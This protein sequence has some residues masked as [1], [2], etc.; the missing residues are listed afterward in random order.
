M[1]AGRV[2]TRGCG[3]F[4]VLWVLLVGAYAY[5][6]YGRIHE[7]MPSG[8]IGVLGGTFALLFISSFVGL[9]TGRRDRVAL[10]RAMSAEPLRDGHLEAVSGP[11]R[12]TGQPLEA[13]FSGQPCVAY[14]YDVKRQG[15]GQ[16]DF[17]GVAMAPCAV[18]SLRGQARV[19]G[20]VT[21]DQFPSTPDDRI[22]RARAVRYLSSAPSEPL[23]VLT[24][25]SVFKELITDD[26]GAI[27][28]DFKIGA[29]TIELSGRRIQERVL[30]AGA[31]VTL[32]GY[33]S[34][35][36]QGFAPTG[37]AMNRIFPGDLVQTSHGMSGSSIKTFGMATFF[38]L[39]LHAM[40][41][42][43]YIMAGRPGGPAAAGSVWDERDCDRQKT[44]L[45]R[46]ADPNERGSDAITPLMNAA[47]MDEAACV[48][49]LIAAGARLEDRD[50]FSDTALAHA[51]VANRDENITVLLEAGAKDFR[52][53]AANGRP[54]ADTDAPVA[55]V[56][57]YIDALYREDFETMARLMA[58]S[59]VRRMEDMRSDLA[60]WQSLRPKTFTA[61]EGWMND[62]AATLTIHG[63]TSTGE[64]HIAYHVARQADGWQ[65][66]KEWFL[67]R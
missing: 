61:G 56:H 50:R 21:L 28:K 32:L 16:S 52:V 39:V 31:M 14:D 65:I 55:A 27:R 11:I 25:L 1:A 47:R 18:E 36:R 20:W 34:E 22:D 6:A 54:I 3:F 10:R 40:L 12:A 60:M 24:I 19:L 33:W 44:M 13:P 37:P 15:Q 7:P 48:S 46:G 51:V 67:E 5:V 45:D 4:F 49:H 8:A 29:D 9:F 64:H 42:T 43:M 30:P 35:S 66:Q 57:E 58:H 63:R 26:D 38:F 59:S 62:E 23:G 2:I 17:A 53:N 41:G